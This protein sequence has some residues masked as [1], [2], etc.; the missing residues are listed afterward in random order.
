MSKTLCILPDRFRSLLRSFLVLGGG[1][2]GFTTSTFLRYQV[3]TVC[4]FVSEVCPRYGSCPYR[5]TSVAVPKSLP[6]PWSLVLSWSLSL[7]PLCIVGPGADN[8]C[9]RSPVFSSSESE[10]LPSDETSV[11]FE[12]YLLGMKGWAC[13]NWVASLDVRVGSGWGSCAFRFF[14]VFQCFNSCSWRF[15][16]N[17]G[18]CDRLLEPGLKDLER[19]VGRPVGTL[20]RF[21]SYIGACSSVRKRR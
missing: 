5:S 7:S 6:R 18:E 16:G 2:G 3:R 4:L 8:V 10:L 1:L 12:L 13:A 17:S 14:S 21:W 20:V 19:P 11:C 15:S 9:S